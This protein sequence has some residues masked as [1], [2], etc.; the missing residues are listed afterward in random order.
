MAKLSSSLSAQLLSRYKTLE[1]TQKNIE[2]LIGKQLVTKRAAH[3]MYESLFLSAHVAIEGFIEQLFLGHLIEK[4]TKQ[5]IVSNMHIVKPR[6][7]VNSARIAR[8]LVTGPNKNYVDWVPYYKT[9]EMAN[10]YFRGGKPFSELTNDEKKLLEKCHI[11]R[12]AIAHKSR[13]SIKQFKNKVLIN[14]SSLP[15]R[16]RNPSGYLSAIIRVSPLQTRFSSYLTQMA[17]IAKK[18]AA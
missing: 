12:N 9:L 1:S 15:P 13:H 3:L 16:E 14:P 18:L 10:L 7:V 2:I 5:C 4:G 8:E 6:I 17:L 11:I